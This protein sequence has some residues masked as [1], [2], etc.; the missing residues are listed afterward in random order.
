MI[1]RIKRKLFYFYFSL[2]F[3]KDKLKILLHLLPAEGTYR[4]RIGNI[5]TPNKRKQ[6]CF[7]HRLLT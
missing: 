1:L 2:F 4:I 3:Y 7:Q 5:I 6:F